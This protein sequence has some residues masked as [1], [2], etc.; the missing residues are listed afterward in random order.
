MIGT[1]TKYATL[2]LALVGLAACS[3]MPKSQTTKDLANA[4]QYTQEEKDAM[5]EEQKIALY[6]ESMSQEK[7][8]VVCRREKPIGSHMTKTVCR[9]RAEIEQD[10]ENSQESLRNTR[11]KPWDPL[12]PGGQ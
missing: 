2:V 12:P 11:G 8:K 3:S 9:T 6:N 1:T 7:S 10:Q 4:P 5:T